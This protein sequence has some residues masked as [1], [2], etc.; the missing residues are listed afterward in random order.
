MIYDVEV[1]FYDPFTKK[2]LYSKVYRIIADNEVE[3]K[4]I[5]FNNISMQEFDN[6]KILDIQSRKRTR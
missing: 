6:F 3:A 5:V 4:K 1:G 2:L